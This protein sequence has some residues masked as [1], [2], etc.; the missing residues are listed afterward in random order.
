MND[1]RDREGLSEERLPCG[2]RASDPKRPAATII[3]A[4]S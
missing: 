3:S 1:G 4:G 2:G